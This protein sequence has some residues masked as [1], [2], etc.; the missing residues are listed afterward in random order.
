VKAQCSSSPKTSTL[1]KCVSRAQDQIILA[2]SKP[3]GEWSGDFQAQIV[4][5]RAGD[6]IPVQAEGKKGLQ[7]VS[8]VR[9]PPAHMQR[10]VDLGRSD[11]APATSFSPH[12]GAALLGLS[13]APIFA[14]M[15]FLTSS[16]AV[17]SAARQACRASNLRPTV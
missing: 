14:S 17:T 15:R 1:P 3:F 2:S 8:P 16:S 9:Q 4:C 7:R 11:L 6:P 12:Q 5:S 10:Q 13:P